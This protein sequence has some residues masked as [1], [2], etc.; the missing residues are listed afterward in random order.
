MIKSVP[1]QKQVSASWR[2]NGNDGQRG[3][4]LPRGRLADRSALLLAN[5]VAE[6]TACQASFEPRTRFEEE[7]PS[8]QLGRRENLVGA[9]S[10][11][12]VI[13]GALRLGGGDHDQPLRAP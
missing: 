3:S 10:S 6:A 2:S 7:R 11:E 9:G 5:L 12:N 13:R 1:F 4:K 8:H